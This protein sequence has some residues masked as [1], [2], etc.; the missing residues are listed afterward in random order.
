MLGQY[1][2]KANLIWA[3]CVYHEPVVSPVKRKWLQNGSSLK[4][5]ATIF[6]EYRDTIRSALD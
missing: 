4:N 6:T 5:E 2:D 3:V 1:W